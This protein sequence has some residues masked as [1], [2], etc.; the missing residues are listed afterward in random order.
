[1]TCA[2]Y[3]RIEL[4]RSPIVGLLPHPKP[5]GTQKTKTRVVTIWSNLRCRS[6]RVS[7]SS[8]RFLCANS[9]MYKPP[10]S[11]L[12]YI[13]IS[14]TIKNVN[15]KGTR[16]S[17]LRLSL[18]IL[19]FIIIVIVGIIIVVIVIAILVV[20]FHA[21]APPI[22]FQYKYIIIKIKEIILKK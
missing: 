20:F 17:C 21:N 11:F 12:D 9:I 13:I 19:V 5:T 10:W 6:W 15:K 2:K 8:N 1:M 7:L 22:L 3:S 18:I 4:M 14:R 16:D